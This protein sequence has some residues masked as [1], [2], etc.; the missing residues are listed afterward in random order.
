MTDEGSSSADEAPVTFHV[1]SSSDARYTLTVPRSMTV[2]ELKGKLA[3]SEYSNFPADRQR[4]IYSGRVL[5][6]PDTLGSYNI[7][8][9]NTIHLVKSA[10]SNQST[11]G[12]GSS[13]AAASSGS[14]SAAGSTLPAPVNLATGPGN[15]PLAGLTGARYAGLAQ[16]PGAQMFGPDGGVSLALLAPLA[17]LDHNI[18]ISW[19]NLLQM[20]APP[21]PENMASMLSDPQFASTL[22]EALMNPQ[23]LDMLINQ[24]PLLRDMGPVA[25]QM[26]RSEEF[27]RMMTDPNALRQ[28][29]EMSRAMGINPYGGMGGGGSGGAFPA[30][31]ITDTTPPNAAGGGGSGSGSGSGN[32]STT[33][34]TPNQPNTTG[35]PMNNPFLGNPLLGALGMG[36]LPGGG[37]NAAA[38]NPFAALFNTPPNPPTTQ[39]SGN[40]QQ[41]PSQPTSDQPQS[42]Q[43]RPNPLGLDPSMVMQ[44]PQALNL[45]ASLLGSGPP[46]SNTNTDSAND[47]QGSTTGASSPPPAFPP[48]LPFGL[49]GPGGAGAAGAAAGGSSSSSTGAA[50][51]AADTR[52]P[53]ERYESQLRQL[54]EMGFF[55]FDRNVE[56]LRRTGGSVNGAVEYLLTH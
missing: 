49:F 30:P 12:A 22:N 44:N 48:F 53:E 54:N 25:R 50:A 28:M 24:S 14:G 40:D 39:P 1:K 17:L 51:A 41:R 47:S 16:L 42:Q 13:S 9:G 11:G 20:G 38:G 10:A 21:D 3:G 56:A 6:D 52:P 36:G 2:L 29:T 26:M 46:G 7:K 35:A 5:K 31:G 43:Q 15:D 33:T 55:D 4:L 34:P 23:V 37:Q 45:L 32:G 18:L 8:E 19:T 27:R